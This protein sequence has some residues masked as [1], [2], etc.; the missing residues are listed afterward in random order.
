[1][2]CSVMLFLSHGV[3]SAID[4]SFGR[5]KK[6]EGKYFTIYCAPELEP[7]VLARNLN[8]APLAGI[9]SGTPMAEESASGDQELADMLDTLFIR[10]CDILDMHLY[11]FKGTIKICRDSAQLNTIYQVLF[12]KGAKQVTRSFYAYSVNTI[13]TSAENFGLGIMGHEIGHMII[14]NYFVV[15]P[16]ERVQEVL[17]AYV[18]FQLRNS[19]Q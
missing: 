19:A 7:Y 1:M 2:L 8:V 4:D 10:V 18:E 3:A 17:S 5:A 6:I 16:P 15:V 9:I 13:Y 12:G 11:T 14:N